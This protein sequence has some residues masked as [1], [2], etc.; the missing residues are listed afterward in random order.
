MEE[1]TLGT[2]IN[3]KLME[4]AQGTISNNA[5]EAKGEFLKPANMATNEENTMGGSKV[6]H[7]VEGKSSMH[8]EN[9]IK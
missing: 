3:I 6:E 9:R 5:L 2:T 8:L 7:R 4:Q 1:T